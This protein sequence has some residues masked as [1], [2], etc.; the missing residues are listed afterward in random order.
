M[1]K[2]KIFFAAIVS[3]TFIMKSEAQIQ[4]KI[5]RMGNENNFMVYALSDETFDTPKNVVSTA[6]VTLVASTG[7]FQV[8]KIINLYANANWRINGQSNAPKE[9]QNA[10]YVY[11]GLENLGTNAFRFTKG[12]ETPLFLIQAKTCEGVISLMDNEKDPFKFPNSQHI[13]VG[14]TMTI[15]GAGGDAFKGVVKDFT[16]AECKKTNAS[17]LEPQQIRVSPNITQ[18]ATVKIEFNRN[19]KDQ[20]RGTIGIY[21]GAG[22]LVW[23]QSI[24]AQKG[25]N[26]ISADLSNLINGIYYVMLSDIKAI[27]IS[28]RLII[29][30]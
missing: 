19:D 11:F 25:Y 22:R 17:T 27:P 10:D 26:A 13:N 30:E 6:Q 15:L 7:A 2:I 29:T 23:S 24:N 28:E 1:K 8:E 4:Y 14:N 12:K 20:E 21:D 18:P 16:K 9:N 3:I 5:E